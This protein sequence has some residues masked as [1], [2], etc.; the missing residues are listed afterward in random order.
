VQSW[1]GFPGYASTHDGKPWK[2]ALIP[3]DVITDSMT[4]QGLVDRYETTD[5]GR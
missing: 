2:Y 5:P 3:H 1:V 4:V